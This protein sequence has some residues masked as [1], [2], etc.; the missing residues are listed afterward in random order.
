MDKML[1]DLP[2]AIAYLDGIIIYTE[3]A[4]EYLDHLQQV[5]Y[6]LHDAK[7]TMDLSKC[8]FFAKEI[9]YLV[10]VLSNTDIK[11]LP[12]K[13]TAIK[14]MN[15]SKTDKQVREF[16]GLVGYYQKFIKNFAHIAKPLA[17]HTQHEAKYT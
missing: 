8:H 3:S 6:K 10:H 4:K 7:L 17:S 9:Q 16:L 14:L 5:F 11:P 2:F 1:K 13:T 12:S 15:P